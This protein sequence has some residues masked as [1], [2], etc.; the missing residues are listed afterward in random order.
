MPPDGQDRPPRGDRRGPQRDVRDGAARRHRGLA[1]RGDLAG[2]PR[3]RPLRALRRRR[4]AQRRAADHELPQPDRRPGRLRGGR[5]RV[6]RGPAAAQGAAP[7]AARVVPDQ[8]R[9]DGRPVVRP[10]PGGLA[11]ALR[12]RARAAGAVRDLPRPAAGAPPDRR[13][14]ARHRGGRP[15]R[16]GRRP[17]PGHRGRRRPGGRRPRADAHRALRERPRVAAPAARV[18]RVRRQ[19]P[20]DLRVL[21][22][23][24]GGGAAGG[25]RGARPVHRVRRHGPDGYRRRPAPDR[26]PGRHLR[27]GRRP[28]GL[29]A[30]GPRARV[31]PGVQRFGPVHLR[32]PVQREGARPREPGAPRRVPHRGRRGPVAGRGRLPRPHRRPGAPPAGLRAAHPP[33]RAA[34]DGAAAAHH[35]ARSRRRCRARRRRPARVRGVPARRGRRR[36]PRGRPARAAAPAGAGV[37]HDGGRPGRRPAR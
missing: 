31:D 28:T 3:V 23:P 32:P 37:H 17:A 33:D 25:R 26:R 9:R 29:P 12:P 20:G 27:R 6:G 7:D 34:G 14:P 10:E 30:V 4:G 11:Q 18:G 21:G 8:V 24:A 36:R 15:G 22:V 16:A 2:D 5:E 1:G 13:A 19:G 35:A